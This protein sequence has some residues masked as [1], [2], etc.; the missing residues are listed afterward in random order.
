MTVQCRVFGI[1]GVASFSI[2]G[3]ARVSAAPP[4]QVENQGGPRLVCVA[5]GKMVVRRAFQS[6]T[7]PP[8]AND[9]AAWKAGEEKPVK[10]SPDGKYQAVEYASDAGRPEALQGM[11]S[12]FHIL[13][14]RQEVMSGESILHV[15]DSEGADNMFTF[16]GWLPD[17]KHFV[18]AAN[19]HTSTSNF[20][21]RC[22]VD[23]GTHKSIAFNGWLSPKGRIALVSSQERLMKGDD[24]KDFDERGKSRG[25]VYTGPKCYLVNPP[26]NLSSYRFRASA[27]KLLRLHST[28][29][30][31]TPTEK[32]EFSSDEQWALCNRYQEAFVISLTT[33]VVTH[34][35]GLNAHF[36]NE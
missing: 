28:S 21:S 29:F 31:L 33:A 14:G 24:S 18:V 32:V 5:H 11:Q 17:S 2:L 3:G 30:F 8:S 27:G 15:I 7:Q 9:R 25:W 1:I 36:T 10:I 35:S 23:I 22:T 4:G 6:Q 26:A 19:S 16:E 20:A 34:L 12:S 13:S